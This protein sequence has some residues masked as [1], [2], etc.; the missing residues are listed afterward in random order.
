MATT[1]RVMMAQGG[2]GGA[3]SPGGNTPGKADEKA[4]QKTG[5]ETRQN[6]YFGQKQ[7]DAYFKR[8]GPLLGC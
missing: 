7:I 1:L 5:P 8:I 4:G 3:G 2:N 6:G